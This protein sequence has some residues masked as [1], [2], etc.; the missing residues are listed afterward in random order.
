MT[1]IEQRVMELLKERPCSCTEIGEHLWCRGRKARQ[2]YARPAGKIIKRL[3]E[4]G[5]VREH[6]PRQA[7]E[8]VRYIAASVPRG[9]K[10]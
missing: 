7:S 5:I 2:S 8:P 10:R 1:D 3:I 6:Y 4:A 9:A